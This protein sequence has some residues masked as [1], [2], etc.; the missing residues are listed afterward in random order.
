MKVERL[1]EEKR[2]LERQLD[3]VRL[4]GGAPTEGALGGRGRSGLHEGDSET[5][6]LLR[7]EQAVLRQE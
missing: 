2:E 6:A 4:G 3:E 7:N 1:N 5:V